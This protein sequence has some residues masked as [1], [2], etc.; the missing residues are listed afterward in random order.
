MSVRTIDPLTDPAWRSLLST[1]QAATLFHSPPWLQAVADAYGFEIRGH[2]ASA[3]SGELTGAVAYC[4]IDDFAGRRI[5]SAP[6]SDA[7]DPL[8]TSAAAWHELLKALQLRGVPL[9]LR[10]LREPSVVATKHI[11]IV[12]TARWQRISLEG[13][14]I[15]DLWR[16][17]SPVARRGVRSSERAAVEV[18]PLQGD[19]DRAAFHQLHVALRKTKYRLLAQPIRFFDALERRFQ[20]EGAWHSLAAYL[21]QRMVAGTVYLRWAD[22]LY[23]KFNASAPDMLYARSNNRLVW[24]GMRL[25]KSL[26]CRYLDLGPSDDDQPGLIRFKRSFGAEEEELRFLRWTPDDWT[27]SPERRKLLAAITRDMTD[28]S[29]SHEVAANAGSVFYRF[30]A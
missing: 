30:F 21:G 1:C 26:G 8:V 16:R 14:S 28:P 6:F 22:T 9:N 27:D 23:Y 11:Q 20:D 15:E 7:C 4:E 19:G 12:K 24:E 29:V 10:C 25:A 17:I 13:C 2:A 5:V 3:P 18:R